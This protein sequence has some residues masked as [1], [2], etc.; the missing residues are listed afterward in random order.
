RL[1]RCRGVPR[2][3]LRRLGLLAHQEECWSCQSE[4]GPDQP[5]IRLQIRSSPGA[6]R[7]QEW[8]VIISSLKSTFRRAESA[9]SWF[10]VGRLPTAQPGM[11]PYRTVRR[12]GLAKAPPAP[13]ASVAASARPL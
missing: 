4:D 7:R 8:A 2:P 5:G 12:T 13:A 10:R 9:A 6:D 1:T 3:C 11:L